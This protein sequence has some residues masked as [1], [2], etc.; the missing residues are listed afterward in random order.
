MPGMRKETTQAVMDGL[1]K[2]L[3]AGG[4]VTTAL[5]APNA[6]QIFDRP[7][8]KLFKNLDKRS[9][10]RELRRVIHYMKQRGLINYNPHDYEHGITLTKAGKDYLKR[11]GD[12]IT[13]KK[14]V[15]W[16]KKWRLV[17]F[18]IPEEKKTKRQAFTNK[19]RQLDFQTLQ[20]S[21]WIHPFPC[22]QIVEVIAETAEV[23]QFV[24]YVEVEHIDNDKV[25][26]ERFNNLLV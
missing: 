25:L 22:K 24:T 21:I 17:F 23:R 6:I 5:A 20:Y 14:P 12:E 1:L 7:L 11:K 18:D 16:D 19:L 15:S 2:F 3:V 4:V 10:E 9:Q 13:I 8:N 26:R